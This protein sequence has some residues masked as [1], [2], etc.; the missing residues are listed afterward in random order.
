MVCVYIHFGRCFRCRIGVCGQ[1]LLCLIDPFIGGLAIDLIGADV[2]EAIDSA[3]SAGTV[4]QV[5]RSD[6][7]V[8][9]E[10]VLVMEG[11]LDVGAS[12]EVHDAIDVVFH[13]DLIDGTR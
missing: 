1:E 7:V 4:E 10:T 6:D 8:Q 11:V 12:G 5:L 2:D 9:S 3:M 13:E